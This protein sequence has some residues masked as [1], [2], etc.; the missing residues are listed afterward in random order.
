MK[1]QKIIAFAAALLMGVG[2]FCFLVV[3]FPT[4]ISHAHSGGLNSQGCHAGSKPYHCHRSQRSVP[5]EYDIPQSRYSQTIPQPGS[6][7][8]RII[9]Q[10][11]TGICN[12]PYNRK[13]NGYR[14]GRSSAWSRPGGAS[15]MCYVEDIKERELL[16]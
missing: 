7:E 13:S 3:A 14:C 6:V 16:E 5:R 4:Q 12:C 2:F 11:W 1:I 15:P 9:K 10:T 8:E